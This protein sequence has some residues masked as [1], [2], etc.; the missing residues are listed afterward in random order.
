MQKLESSVGGK[1]EKIKERDLGNGELGQLKRCLMFSFI[2]VLKDIA[3]GWVL[4]PFTMH[5][6]RSAQL[7]LPSMNRQ[8]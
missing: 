3:V 6:Q 4:V 7:K 5:R 8:L 2:L 1:Y